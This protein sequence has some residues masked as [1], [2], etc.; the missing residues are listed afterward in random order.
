MKGSTTA[1]SPLLRRRQIRVYFD[2]SEAELGKPTRL[3]GAKNRGRFVYKPS[4]SAKA[5][6]SPTSDVD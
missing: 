4:D 6:L 1:Q 2:R 3:L 5:T